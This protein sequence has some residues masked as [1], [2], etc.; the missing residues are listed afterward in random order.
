MKRNRRKV[1][2]TPIRACRYLSSPEA[3]VTSLVG[4]LDAY[5]S[6]CC[7]AGPIGP[8]GPSSPIL[9]I[10]QQGIVCF[11]IQTVHLPQIM[12]VNGRAGS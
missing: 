3:Q 1:A 10:V 2:E 12:T 9:T 6:T 4:T 8:L 7:V 5:L 11:P